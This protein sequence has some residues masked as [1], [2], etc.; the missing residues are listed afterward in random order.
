M[1]TATTSSTSK[2]RQPTCPQC[3]KRFRTATAKKTYCTP[4][5]QRE[6]TKLKRRVKH[7]ERATNSAFFYWIAGEVQR[8]GTLQILTGHDANSLV[9]LH[10]L[11]KDCLKANAYGNNKQFA[12]S[13]I[14]PVKGMQSVGRL[15]ASNLVIAPESLNRVHG[16]RHFGYGLSVSKH[17][18]VASNSI[19]R[20][21]SLK[22][23]N[24]SRRKEV[25]DRCL[26]YLGEEVVA[27][28]V[29][30]AKIQ[31]TQR[32]KVMYWLHQNLDQDNAEQKVYLDQLDEMSTKALTALKSDIQGKEA[33]SFSPSAPLSTPISVMYSELK[34][35]AVIRPE[36]NSIAAMVKAA[37]PERSMKYSQAC[38]VNDEQ[39]QAL[40]DV[41]HGK[42][43]DE[44]LSVFIEMACVYD[45]RGEQIHRCIPIRFV[46]PGKALVA[47]V[48]APEKALQM[49][50]SFADELD[51]V[52]VNTPPT[53]LKGLDYNPLDEEF[54]LF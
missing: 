24:S 39:V 29:K 28:A 17:D 48:Q 43:V 20:E 19:A 47:P 10:Q 35:H 26:Q 23:A 27:E 8:A 5:C 37:I 9:E 18:L 12:I 51:G 49:F 45:K 7:T 6:A 40:F 52:I 44:V 15:H 30:L 53:L 34:R 1:K 38:R 36:L 31:P 2:K 16:T 33:N 11:F 42:S 25:L 41:L 14:A 13:H 22:D 54:I 50:A 46:R 32:H 21:S 3:K 4:T